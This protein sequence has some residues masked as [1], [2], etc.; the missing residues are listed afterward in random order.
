M[1]DG[2]EKK[3]ATTS[4]MNRVQQ[5]RQNFLNFSTNGNARTT[6]KKQSK[7][8]E[9]A[10]ALNQTA[11][12]SEAN[13]IASNATPP[14]AAATPNVTT[15]A[16]ETLEPIE[17]DLSTI[18]GGN[19]TMKTLNYFELIQEGHF[20]EWVKELPPIALMRSYIQN[21]SQ[22]ALEKTWIEC[23]NRTCE[24]F[25]SMQFVVGRYSCP[26]EAGNRLVRF[27][28]HLVWAI[29][30]NRVFLWDYWDMTACEEEIKVPSVVCPRLTINS[31]AD[32]KDI[33]QLASWV[34]SWDEWSLKL[35]LT[36][37]LSELLPSG[38]R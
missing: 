10:M 23:G 27:M 22:Q 37:N 30:T 17:I 13:T 1:Y 6:P 4:S 14:T 33:L 7:D 38:A 35:N 36:Q 29:V 15:P 8:D 21:H 18:R 16:K 3:N 28:N 20:G 12:G 9:G 2:G 25:D 5:L 32:C 19:A 34:P 24:K 11:A 31:V 26:A